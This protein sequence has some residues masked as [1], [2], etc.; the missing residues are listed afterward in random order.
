VTDRD[1]LIEVEEVSVRPR[2]DADEY[3][4]IDSG[5]VVIL[6]KLRKVIVQKI[7]K[8]RYGW[9]FLNRDDLDVDEH[10]HVCL[11]CPARDE[12]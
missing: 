5:Y 11:D 12:S 6:G 4:I 3:G 8:G 9:K 1:L 10:T 7:P 2:S